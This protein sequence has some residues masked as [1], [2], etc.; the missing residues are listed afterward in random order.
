MISQGVDFVK[1]L[2]QDSKAAIEIIKALE[3]EMDGCPGYVRDLAADSKYNDLRGEV[4]HSMLA[5][6]A[7]GKAE[8]VMGDPWE[9]G[10]PGWVLAEVN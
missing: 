10:K 8:L 7:L 2:E 5:L 3:A 6:W 4:A 1:S 9:G